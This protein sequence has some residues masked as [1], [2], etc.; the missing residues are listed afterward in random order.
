[1]IDRDNA[2][3]DACDGVVDMVL[4]RLRHSYGSY[5]FFTERDLVWTLQGWFREELLHRDLPHRVFSDFPMLPGSRRALSADLALVL[6]GKAD[7]VFELKYEPSHNRKRVDIWENKFPVVNWKDVVNDTVRIEQFV[8]AEKC[9]K[10]YAMLIDEGQYF[11]K[12]TISGNGRWEDWEIPGK[13]GP[14]VSVHICSANRL[15]N[16]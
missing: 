12:R 8:K 10:A 7:V 15:S 14:L 13:P 4:E 6:D 5:T 2:P 1:M 16:G 9:R 3:I 11:R